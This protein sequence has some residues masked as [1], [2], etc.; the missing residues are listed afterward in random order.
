MDPKHLCIAGFSDGASYSISLGV[1]NGF[2]FT[3]IIGFSPGSLPHAACKSV[4]IVYTVIPNALQ[5]VRTLL[6][7]LN[8]NLWSFVPVLCSGFIR[9]QRYEDAPLIYVSHGKRDSV[10]HIGNCSRRLVPK[11]LEHKYRVTY[12]EFDGGHTVPA[13]IAEE[14]LTWVM[15]T[16]DK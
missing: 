12:K 6:Y 5:G 8:P 10:L 4:E 1:C 15:Q 11:L 3:H 7:L 13:S 14:A 2:F 9:V 16:T